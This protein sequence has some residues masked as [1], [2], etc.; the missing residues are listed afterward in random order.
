MRNVRGQRPNIFLMVFLRKNYCSA[1]RKEQISIYRR[2]ALLR[3]FAL[4]SARNNFRVLY[5]ER[6]FWQIEKGHFQN[7]NSMT[8]SAHSFLKKRQF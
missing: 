8:I 2:L 5:L 6:I 7:G 1:I 4:L 3:S